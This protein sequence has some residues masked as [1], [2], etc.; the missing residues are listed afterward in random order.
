M[1][2]ESESELKKTYWNTLIHSVIMFAGQSLMQLVDMVFCGKLGANAIATVGTSTSLF[3]WFM[4]VGNGLVYCLEYLIPHALGEK[5]DKEAHSFYYSGL[6]VSTLV[7]V[8]ST[9]GLALLAFNSALIGTNLAIQGDVTTFSTIIALSYFPVFLI[10]TLR[11]EL[12]ARGRPNESTYAFLIGNILNVFLNWALIF[13]HAG[14]PE[15]GLMGSAWANVISRFGIFFYLLAK[16]LHVR[17]KLESIPIHWMKVN[18]QKYGGKIL[19][20]GFPSSVHMLFEMGAFI[21]VSTLASSM[22]TT[23]N[24]AHSIILSIATF[25]FMIPL[26]LGSAAALTLSKLNGEKRHAL[27]IH[28]GWS[29]IKLGWGYALISSS[30]LIVFQKPL[31]ALYTSDA[32]TTAM[33]ASILFIAAIFQAADATQVIIAG[34]LRGFG[35]VKIQAIANGVGHWLI[36][37]PIGL[38]FAYR[39]N[40][41]VRGLWVGLSTGLFFVA[42]TLFYFWKKT[43]R[44]QS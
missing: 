37:L 13:G 5:N 20:M 36:G 3:A 23:Q 22:A 15:L 25:V 29:T 41:Q 11:V 2:L 17:S 33:G 43:T 9:A 4:V 26:G 24:A 14:L 8:F 30:F 32:E 16:T 40:W 39:L 18:Y 31:F 10:P 12:Q 6:M 38:F 42:I 44:D 19:R 7:S 1:R 35:K 21:L 34:C 27:A 28:Y